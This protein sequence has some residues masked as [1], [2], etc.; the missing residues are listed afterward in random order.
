MFNDLRHHYQTCQCQTALPV[1]PFSTILKHSEGSF[2]PS[3]SAEIPTITPH[4]K[5]LT[6]V[7]D[8]FNVTSDFS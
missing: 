1:M 7:Y 2:P 3:G 8:V 4:R 6:P 5:Q